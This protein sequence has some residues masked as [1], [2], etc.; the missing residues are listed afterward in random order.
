MAFAV[1]FATRPLTLR[2]IIARMDQRLAKKRWMTSRL[3]APSVMASPPRL[4]APDA[5]PAA[6]LSASTSQPQASAAPEVQTGY[7]TFRAKIIGMAPL[8][9]HSGRLAD[10]LSEASKELRR[11]TKK[12]AKTDADLEYMARVEWTGGLWLWK[13]APCIPGEAIEACFVAAARKSKRGPAAKAGVLSPQHWPLEYDG[14]RVLD[15]MWADGGFRLTAGVRVGQSRVMRTRPMF[16]RW[17]A[18]VAIEY[19]D[20]QLDEREV[21]DILRTAGRIVGIGD[22]RPR[23][24]RFEVQG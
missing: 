20:D 15:E 16:A 10:P 11:I 3:S 7:R 5:M 14:P 17:S 1:G 22:W 9:M 2:S 6:L 24:G 8:L 13:G 12:R 18:E 21:R 19:L 23:F 4:S